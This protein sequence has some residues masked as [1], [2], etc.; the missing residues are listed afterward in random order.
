MGCGGAGVRLAGLLG[1][2]MFVKKGR[3][4]IVHSAMG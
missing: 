4:V 1:L 3:K 2:G